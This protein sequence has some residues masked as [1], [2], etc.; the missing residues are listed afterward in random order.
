MPSC[1]DDP[2]LFGLARCAFLAVVPFVVG[3][4]S[5]AG[6]RIRRE[7]KVCVSFCKI[8]EYIRVGDTVHRILEDL[9]NGC[10]GKL[11]TGACELTAI[12]QPGCDLCR[13]MGLEEV[14][15]NGMYDIQFLRNFL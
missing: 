13:L 12:L 7:P 6:A 2:V 4:K 8:R 14:L 3:E 1:G 9:T 10:R 11:F 15:I 5:L